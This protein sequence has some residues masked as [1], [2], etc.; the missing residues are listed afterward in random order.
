MSEE[1]P[2]DPAEELRILHLM[3]RR[4]SVDYER[5]ISDYKNVCITNDCLKARLKAISDN[6]GDLHTELVDLLDSL[7][8]PEYA[9]GQP[10]FIR[11]VEHA[12]GYDSIRDHRKSTR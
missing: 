2:N 4:L 7:Y 1:T 10:Q 9:I 3:H 12:V 5:A 8:A 6:H 11:L